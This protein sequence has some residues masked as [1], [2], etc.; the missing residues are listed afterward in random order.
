[1]RVYVIIQATKG[2]ETPVILNPGYLY[3]KVA[4]K[5]LEELTAPRIAYYEWN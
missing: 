1:M 2:V 5:K 4:E 3:I